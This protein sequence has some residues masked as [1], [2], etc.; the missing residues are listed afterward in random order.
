MRSVMVLVMVVAVLVGPTA[1]QASP[2]DDLLALADRAAGWAS[3][4]GLNPLVEE[5]WVSDAPGDLP[6][7][8][9]AKETVVTAADELAW[10]AAGY[11][12]VGDRDAVDRLAAQVEREI[13]RAPDERF[14]AVSRCALALAYERLGDEAAADQQRGKAEGAFALC[15]DNVFA[16]TAARAGRHDRVRALLDGLGSDAARFDE[17]LRVAAGYVD[18]GDPDR[19]ATAITEAA[20]LELGDSGAEHRLTRLATAWASAGDKTKARTAARAARALIVDDPDRLRG[21]GREVVAALA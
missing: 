14:D 4:A 5:R 18:R 9:A 12:A 17:L 11:A 10:L 13:T 8:L 19:A 7:L 15:K 21:D 20:G 2:R 3:P 16:A 6:A 1:A